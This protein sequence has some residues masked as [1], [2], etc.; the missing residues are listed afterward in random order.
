MFFTTNTYILIQQPNYKKDLVRDL[1]YNKVL[2][3]QE[4]VATTTE[5]L[6]ET[7]PPTRWHRGVEDDAYA[8]AEGPRKAIVVEG[9]TEPTMSAHS[10]DRRM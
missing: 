3:H 5:M 4:Q 7:N 2:Q 6:K 10:D 9:T 1:D 8:R